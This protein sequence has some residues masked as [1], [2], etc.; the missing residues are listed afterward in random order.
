MTL[1]VL[2][3]IKAKWKLFAMVNRYSSKLSIILQQINTP[4][5]GRFRSGLD[6]EGS[7]CLM[8]KAKH[9]SSQKLALK[10]LKVG[11][12]GLCSCSLTGL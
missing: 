12:T 1:A 9:A 8:K 3:K 10:P 2:L 11:S 5:S 6:R 4:G 7:D